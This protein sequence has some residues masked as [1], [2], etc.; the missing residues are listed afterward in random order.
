MTEY[1]QKMVELMKQLIE[2]Q[3]KT[4]ETM[5]EMVD[6]FKKYDIEDAMNLENLREG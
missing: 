6:L 5:R 2:R 1:E 4:N 3:E